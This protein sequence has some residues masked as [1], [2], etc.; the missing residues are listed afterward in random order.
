VRSIKI[1]LA[2]AVTRFLK[3]GELLRTK[4]CCLYPGSCNGRS[5]MVVVEEANV[6][7]PVKMK[8]TITK[9]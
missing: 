9:S 1:S 6:R 4:N 8:P 3:L 7:P 5:H 2:E